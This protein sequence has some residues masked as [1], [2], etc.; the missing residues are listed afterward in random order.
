[1]TALRRE[2]ADHFPPV[3]IVI[4][5]PNRASREIRRRTPAFPS[6]SLRALPRRRAAQSEAGS[7]T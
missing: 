1:M 7:G 5:L 6:R 2:R 3:T 4:V